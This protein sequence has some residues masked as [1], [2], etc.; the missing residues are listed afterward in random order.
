M[1]AKGGIR[2]LA[3]VSF[4]CPL[5][6]FR[7]EFCP[8]SVKVEQAS[9]SQDAH[10][11][12]RRKAAHPSPQ[13]SKKN[14]GGP[15][16]AQGGEGAQSGV[17]KTVFVKVSNTLPLANSRGHFPGSVAQPSCECHCDSSL[18]SPPLPAE[19]STAPS[20]CPSSIP[21]ALPHRLCSSFSQ[22][23]WLFSLPG[24]S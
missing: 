3:V 14:A 23:M 17:T 9:C 7:D 16:P 5:T 1:L 21:G 10:A 12:W 2:D 15:A 20:W 13:S 24:L 18:P 22:A 8:R 4:K 6:D 11:Q 19:N